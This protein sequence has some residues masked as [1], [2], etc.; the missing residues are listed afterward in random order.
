M[1]TQKYTTFF[2]GFLL[3]CQTLQGQEFAFRFYN[4]PVSRNNTILPNAWAGGFNSAQFSSIKLDADNQPDLVVF[5]RTSAKV[6]CFLATSNGYRHAPEYEKAFPPDLR[7]WMLLRDYNNDGKADIFTYQNSG[8]RVFKNVSSGN[9][10]SF[11]LAS[12]LL[13]T[14]GFASDSFN[15]AVLPLDIPAILDV[16]ADGDLDIL[17]SDV[18]GTLVEM[19]KN[20]SQQNGDPE[21]FAYR[22]VNACWGKFQEIEDCDAFSFGIDCGL[23]EGRIGENERTLH[24]GSTLL[25]EDVDGDGK[26]DALIGDVSCDFLYKLINTGTTENTVFQGFDKNFPQSKPAA[27]KLFPAAYAE[28]VNGD[29]VKDLLVSSNSQLNDGNQIDFRQSAWFYQNTGTNEKPDY[30]FQQ[31]DFLQNTMLDFGENA[32]PA[33]AD[34]DADG[35]LDLLAGSRGYLAN[36]VFRATLFFY[37]NTGTAQNPAFQLKTEDF[38]GL[39]SQNFTHLK[40]FFLDID[41]N[42]SLDLG[43]T[44]TATG[45]TRLRYLPNTAARNEPMQF[46]PADLRIFNFSNLGVSDNPCLFDVDLDGDWDVLLGKANGSLAFYRNSSNENFTLVKDNFLGLGENFDAR[47]LFPAIAD[48]N[49]DGKPDLLTGDD[50]GVLSLYS[51]FRDSMNTTIQPRSR[52]LTDS[53][54]QAFTQTQFGNRLSPALADLDGDG[55]PEILTGLAGGGVMLLKNNS[56]NG[57]TIPTET[58]ADFYPNPTDGNVNIRLSGEAQIQVYSYTGKLVWQKEKITEVSYVLDMSQLAD[59]LYLVRISDSS[60]TRVR[61]VV[62]LR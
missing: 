56:G 53:L 55:L 36:G 46:N 5:D 2:L 23:T 52:L 13:N 50:R 25:V 60:G 18:G 51:A 12:D 37:E 35:D 22:K 10:L 14:K 4:I 21:K 47:N 6:T 42:G 27:F 34:I 32:A 54:K 28:D 39:S 3:F 20:Y 24:S 30:Q 8:V 1:M 9:N 58:G 17:T 7:F 26:K 59:G 57:G 41:R 49:R 33:L 11:Q 43:F 40:P 38:Q 44:A 61:K 31:P 29:G 15:L 62:V 16:D 19:H 45:E 48:L